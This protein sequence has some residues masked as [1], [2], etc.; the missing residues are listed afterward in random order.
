MI[1]PLFDHIGTISDH[2]MKVVAQN[3]VTQD[4]HPEHGGKCLQSSPDPLPSIGIVLFGHLVIPG[5]KGTAYAP[6]HGVSDVDFEWIKRFRA[7]GSIHS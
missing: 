6:L 1:G 2:N 4:I 3:G 5:E 7:I